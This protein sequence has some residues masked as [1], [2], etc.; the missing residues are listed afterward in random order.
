M[1]HVAVRDLGLCD[2]G[3]GALGRHRA[4]HRGAGRHD[5]RRGGMPDVNVDGSLVQILAEREPYAPGQDV[6]L[7]AS[8]SNP[9]DKRNGDETVLRTVAGPESSG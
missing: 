6:R 8:G 5:G 2:D 4:R 3:A 7:C 9:A 1:D